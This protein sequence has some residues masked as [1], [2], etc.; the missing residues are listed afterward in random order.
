MNAGVMI[1]EQL[2]QCFPERLFK[3]IIT[4]EPTAF[5]VIWKVVGALLDEKVKKKVH[6]VKAK[7][8]AATLG[9][10]AS[11]LPTWLGGS[12]SYVYD[13]AHLTA[14]PS[15][16]LSVRDG[17]LAHVSSAA[18]AAAPA[19]A[20]SV[21]EAP[22]AAASTEAPVAAAALEAGAPAVSSVVDA[23]AD[24]ASGDASAPE[25]PTAAA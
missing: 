5:W 21:V 3:L 4:R 11:V 23:P 12:S 15:A 1:V 10:D 6:F 14:T 20:A 9:V 22:V 25:S 8:V 2:M 18:V 24:A 7:H 19:A 17:P 16:W 13:Y